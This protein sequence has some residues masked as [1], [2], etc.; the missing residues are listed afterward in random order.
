M[1]PQLVIVMPAYNER[2]CIHS[3]V[4]EWLDLARRVGGAR[5]I[6]VNDG[7]TDSTDRILDQL[8]AAHPELVVIH[9]QN[10]GH[11]CA[12]VHGYREALASG[13]EW[14]FQTDSDAQMVAADFDK[15]WQRRTEWPFVL[16]WRRARQDHRSR[17]ALSGAHARLLGWLFEVSI[18]DANVPYRLMSAALLDRYLRQLPRGVFAPNVLLSVLAA[19]EGVLAPPVEVEHRGRSTGQQSI[20]GW[21]TAG[22]AWRCL[23]EYWGFRRTALNA[24]R[25]C[26]IIEK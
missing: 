4:S 5:V 9:Q 13:C 17:V 15:L 6:V 1:S 2:E 11:G 24:R 18:D 14:V 16:G 20:R 12:L 25:G 3:S 7:S 23:R 26:A 19:R 8:V 10:G 21:K 22:I